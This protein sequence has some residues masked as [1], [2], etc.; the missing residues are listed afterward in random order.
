MKMTN[1]IAKRYRKDV[2]EILGYAKARNAIMSHFDDEDKKDAPIQGTLGG[3]QQMTIITAS[4]G[5][6]VRMWRAFLAM[7]SQKMRY[8]IMLI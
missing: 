6:W 1:S 5:S 8:Q 3:T 4:L 7:Q 2:A